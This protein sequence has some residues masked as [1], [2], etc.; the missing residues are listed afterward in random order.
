MNRQ[1]GT[2]TKGREMFYAATDKNVI[3]HN[4]HLVAVESRKQRDDLCETTSFRPMSSKEAAGLPQFDICKERP[5][6]ITDEGRNMTGAVLVTNAG[7]VN[8][9]HWF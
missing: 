6:Q 1:E 4:F 2:P 8:S 9:V 7:N 5:F 3:G